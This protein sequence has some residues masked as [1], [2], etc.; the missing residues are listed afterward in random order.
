MSTTLPFRRSGPAAVPAAFAAPVPPQ[1]RRS[2][3]AAGDL[4]VRQVQAVDAWNLARHERE[5]ALALLST[6]RS[7]REAA[8]RS[9]DVLQRTHEAIADRA[10]RDLAHSGGPWVGRGVTA[11]VAHR[12]AWFLDQLGSQLWA[13]GIT[14][15]HTTDNAADLLGTVVA[16]QPDLVV[17]GDRLAMM[18]VEGL[19]EDC[20]RFA[21]HSRQVV[22]VSEPQH[23]AS[24]SPCPRAHVVRHHSPGD[25]ADAVLAL[26]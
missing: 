8:K 18:H 25:L 13:R 10:A 17:L 16:E 11:V 9:A 5:A 21:A 19:L 20:G 2:A 14:V 22:N 26:A 15:L 7:D 12:H 4:L 23:A 1:H 3:T 6:S 24:W